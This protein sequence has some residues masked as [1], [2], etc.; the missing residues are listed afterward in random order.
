MQPVMEMQREV[1][2]PAMVRVL[3]L[4]MVQM[5]AGGP[6]VVVEVVGVLGQALAGGEDVATQGLGELR[7]DV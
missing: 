6:R 1:Q 2:Q 7:S 3:A 4:Q 5:T